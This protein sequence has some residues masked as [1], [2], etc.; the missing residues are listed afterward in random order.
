MVV[1][2]V[3]LCPLCHT[4][5]HPDDH[6]ALALDGVERIQTMVYLLFRIVPHR[7][8]VQEHRI[9]L[10]QILR[11][12]VARHPHHAGHHLRVCHVHLTAVCLNI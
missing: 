9:R 3:L 4:A 11:R 10:V 7:T 8:S 12:L 2:Q 6:R 5:Q 1:E